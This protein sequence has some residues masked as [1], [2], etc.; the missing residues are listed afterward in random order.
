MFE[1][2]RGKGAHSGKYGVCKQDSIILQTINFLVLIVDFFSK[3]KINVASALGQ[4]FLMDA[5]I[6]GPLVE[7]DVHDAKV[8]QSTEYVQS[9]KCL[10]VYH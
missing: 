3:M 7:E 2:M 1:I 10:Y 8:C 6:N 9:L 5:D 4:N